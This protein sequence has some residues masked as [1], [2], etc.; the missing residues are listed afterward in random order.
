MSETLH[1]Q[2]IFSQWAQAVEAN[3][4]AYED[5]DLVCRWVIIGASGG[6]WVTKCKE[7]SRVFQGEA[8]VD[9]EIILSDDDFVG[10]ACGT[11][12]PQQ[13]FLKGHL[14]IKG[15]LEQVIKLNLLIDRLTA[16]FQSS[17]INQRQQI[18]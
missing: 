2:V 3:P 10:L 12:N 14:N 15:N 4:E 7:R 9:C 5:I 17:P 13:A 11:L 1:P 18:H 8:T 16:F 6:T